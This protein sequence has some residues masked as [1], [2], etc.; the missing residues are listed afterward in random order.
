M[1]LKVWRAFGRAVADLH[2]RNILRSDIDD[3]NRVA[4]DP[5]SDEASF[6]ANPFGDVPL[7]RPAAPRELAQ[8]LL[9]LMQF[10]QASKVERQSIGVWDLFIEV[11]LKSMDERGPEVVR[12]LADLQSDLHQ[13][14][15]LNMKALSL[16]YLGK[17]TEAIAAFQEC[18]KLRAT[19]GD[20][21]GYCRTLCNLALVHAEANDFPKAFQMVEAAISWGRLHRRV[22]GTCLALFQKG[23]LL[24]RQGKRDEALRWV[25]Q[26]IQTW[27]RTGQPIPTQFT[28]LADALRR[29][30]HPGNENG[31]AGEQDD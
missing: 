16:A 10:T 7:S 26:A 15:E 19:A 22:K 8:N 21:E 4:Y 14:S 29:N 5:A 30:I 24:N 25:D 27:E 3:V 13:A 11:Y 20:H 23:L 2:R 9:P 12:A 28:A 6:P 31:E 18:L 1:K 17:T